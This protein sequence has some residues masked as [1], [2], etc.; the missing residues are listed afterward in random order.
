MGLIIGLDFLRRNQCNIDIV[1][2]QLHLNAGRLSTP[3]LPES[4]LP[5]HAKTTVTE[6]M[7]QEAEE[8]FDLDDMVEVLSDDDR[9]KV[10]N[11]AK[12]GKCNEVEAKELL[13][14]HRWNISAAMLDLLTEKVASSSHQQTL[15]Q[16]REQRF[17]QM[18]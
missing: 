9:R 10:A 6:H 16:K 1:A 3:F 8:L 13:H 7:T 17:S 5:M 14:R 15:R 4:E 11:L 18:R 12:V 2:N